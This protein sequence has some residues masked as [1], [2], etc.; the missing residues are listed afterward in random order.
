M[1]TIL[2]EIERICHLRF[3]CNNLNNEKLF[4]IFF[5]H[6][7]NLTQILNILKKKIIV[8]TTWFRNL[9]TVKDLF[10]PLSKKLRFR[11]IST[12]LF[13][14]ERICGP[15]FKCSY[16]K[17]ETLSTILLFHFW[18]LHQIL[19]IFKKKMILIATLFPKLQTVKELLRPL[20]KKH[21][22]RTLFDSQ[23]V[24][25]SQN[26]AKIPWEQFYHIFS[27]LSEN[28]IWKISP[29]VTC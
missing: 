23:L 5:F 9:Q 14:I 29:S 15:R 12:I 2:Y 8:I 24:K 19:N 21:H 25:R 3:K 1:T 22:F 10:R 6:I 20:S 28:L 7:W 11:T 4:V 18:N 17:N 26:V 16:L 13:R 27:L